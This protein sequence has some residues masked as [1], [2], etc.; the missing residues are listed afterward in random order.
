[1]SRVKKSAD[2][3]EEAKILSKVLA[4]LRVSRGMT[5]RQVAKLASLNP[6]RICKAERGQSYPRGS[7]LKRILAG[8]GRGRQR[9]DR[10]PPLIV[11]D[12]I[13]GAER[14][15]LDAL[16]LQQF[17]NV[18]TSS[19][20]HHR[21]LGHRHNPRDPYVGSC[22]EP[23]EPLGH[24]RLS[25]AGNRRSISGSHCISKRYLLPVS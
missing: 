10:N 2:E 20:D 14:P 3:I 22:R 18:A 19:G 23:P 16:S 17:H 24:Q 8:M 5:Q 11:C 12:R 7:N 15:G 6:Q 21:T 4:A 13:P 25:C 9:C 1:M